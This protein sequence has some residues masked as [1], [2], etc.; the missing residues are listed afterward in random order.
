M[1]E[2]RGK[3]IATKLIKEQ[4]RHAIEKKYSAVT[5]KSSPKWKD[6]LRLL[7]LLDFIIVGYKANEWGPHAAI[8][9]EK[10]LL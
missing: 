5:V 6:M 1:P 8:F 4:E 7:I 2:C 3:G 9:F 10:S